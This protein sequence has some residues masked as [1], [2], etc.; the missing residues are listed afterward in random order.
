MYI[1]RIVDA[2]AEG[3]TCPGVCVFSFVSLD[4]LIELLQKKKVSPSWTQKLELERLLI[5]LSSEL[6]AVSN[7]F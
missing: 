7:T 6:M 1:T 4:S 2:F 5:V 3:R